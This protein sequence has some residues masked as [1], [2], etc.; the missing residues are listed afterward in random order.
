MNP[1]ETAGAEL[2]QQRQN[3]SGNSSSARASTTPSELWPTHDEKSGTVFVR[4]FGRGLVWAVVILAAITGVRSWIVP[5]KA[6][7]PAPAPTKSAPGYP[8]AEAQAL[9]ARFARAYLTWDEGEPTERAELLAAVLPAG[10]DTQMGW[11]GKG[12]QEVLAVQPGAVSTGDDGQARVRVE[13]LIQRSTEAPP[14]KGKKKAPTPGAA[15][16]VGL[17]VPVVRTAGRVIVTGQPGMV[18]IPARGPKAPELHAPQADTELSAATEGVVD[19]FLRAYSTGDTDTVT[20]PGASVPPLAEGVKYKELTSWSADKGSGTD[21]T[22]T[23]R[24]SWEISGAEIE[25]TYRVEL[26][27]VSSADAQRWQ[28][29]AVRGGTVTGL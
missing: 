16:W 27:R 12:S 3:T 15:H 1:W 25:Q 19:R 5:P 8:S 17:D 24:V 28:V 6:P 23:A 22:G 9:A 26:T 4:R 21:R 13:A 18:G 2:I 14:T 7:A 20:A 11:D 10:A 29:T